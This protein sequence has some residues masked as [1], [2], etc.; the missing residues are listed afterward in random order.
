MSKK[1][2]NPKT[3]AKKGAELAV[4]AGVLMFAFAQVIETQGDKIDLSD[5]KTWALPVALGLLKA[6][7]NWRKNRDRV[8]DIDDLYKEK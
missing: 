8:I 5:W 4:M 1:H 3:T 7:T 6:F 2:Y